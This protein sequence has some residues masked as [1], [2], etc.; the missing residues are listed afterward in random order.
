MKKYI[1]SIILFCITFYAN[2]QS[3]LSGY[4][5]NTENSEAIAGAYVHI[6]ELQKTCLSDKN[7]FYEFKDLPQGHFH[8]QFSMLGYASLVK[9][10][11]IAKEPV[12]LS[13]TLDVQVIHSQEVVVSAGSYMT[14]HENAVKVETIRAKELQALNNVSY[15]QSM[16]GTR[17]K[18]EM[19]GLSN[20]E[21]I[22][23]N[24]AELKFNVAPKELY[25]NMSPLNEMWLIAYNKD[26]EIVFFKDF[27]YGQ[28]YKGA[29]LDSNEYS[30]NVTRIIQDWIDGDFDKNELSVYLSIINAGKDF[31]RSV[32]NT[33]Q[34]KTP[35]K[36]VITYT[37]Y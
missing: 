1:L 23:V 11:N 6:P 7:G 32:L 35:P 14:Q 4:I 18:L 25:G 15:L 8:V 26:E 27:F 30:F 37:K 36:L 3:A 29:E 13:I 5:K 2:A 17:I 9:H 31:K 12:S 16:A 34:N 20:F 21:N 10:V 19:P 22:I 28:N 33:G 24:K